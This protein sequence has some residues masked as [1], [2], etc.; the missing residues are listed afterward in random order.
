MRMASG[1]TAAWMPVCVVLE[2]K[3]HPIRTFILIKSLGW[4]DSV[5]Q[6]ESYP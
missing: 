4:H 6:A 1:R 2:K 3:E 5:I